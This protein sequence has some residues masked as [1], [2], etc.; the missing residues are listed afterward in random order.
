MYSS[1]ARREISTESLGSLAFG[2][3]FS[4][5]MATRIPGGM[6]MVITKKIL[7]VAVY[8]TAFLAEITDLP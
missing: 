4:F 5:S 1:S 7:D 8:N 6:K 2:I 3:S